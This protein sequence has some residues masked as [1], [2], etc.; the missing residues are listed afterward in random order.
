MRN[1]RQQVETERDALLVEEAERG[2]RQPDE[3][4]GAVELAG[5]ATHEQAGRSARGVRAAR[6]D[7]RR[8]ASGLGGEQAYGPVRDLRDA[9]GRGLV[10]AGAPAHLGPAAPI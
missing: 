7:R 3:A 2:V 4:T 10:D 1:M 9:G 8:E 6:K 5:G